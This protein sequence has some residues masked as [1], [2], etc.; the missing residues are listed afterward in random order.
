MASD[1][2]I[3]DDLSEL[4]WKLYRHTLNWIE[5]NMAEAH[6]GREA[7]TVMGIAFGSASFLLID[8]SKDKVVGYEHRWAGEEPEVKVK[9]PMAQLIRQHRKLWPKGEH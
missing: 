9:A 1:D 3:P 4:G 8:R 7:L 2:K 6:T 5:D